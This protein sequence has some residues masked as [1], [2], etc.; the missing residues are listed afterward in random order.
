[1]WSAIPRTTDYEIRITRHTNPTQS[2][3]RVLYRW[4][5]YEPFV[6]HSLWIVL[7][8]DILQPFVVASE[9]HRRPVDRCRA[10]RGQRIAIRAYVGIRRTSAPRHAYADEARIMKQHAL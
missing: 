6:E 5:N 4:C 2:T 7:L 9:V 8:L 1:M 10:F 3:L